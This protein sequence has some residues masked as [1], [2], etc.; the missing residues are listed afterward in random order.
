MGRDIWH[1]IPVVAWITF[2]KET[3]RYESFAIMIIEEC[4]CGGIIKCIMNPLYDFLGTLLSFFSEISSFKAIK[5]WLEEEHSE[6][7]SEEIDEN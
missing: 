2:S 3:R 1:V 4:S 5:D 7:A 6:T